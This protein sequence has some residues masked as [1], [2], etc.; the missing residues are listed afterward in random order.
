MLLL[1]KKEVKEDIP[2]TD[3][4]NELIN[5]V[6]A[7]LKPEMEKSIESKFNNIKEI[8]VHEMRDI[9]NIQP[10]PI[11]PLQQP[12]MQ[13]IPN[14]PQGGNMD[15]MGM[16]FPLLQNVLKPNENNMSNL[17]AEA[18][19]RKMLS[20]TSRSEVLNQAMMNHLFK[21]VFKDEALLEDYNKT[22]NSFMSPI[23]K[24]GAKSEEKK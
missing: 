10:Q 5:N 9:R 8:I 24:F 19:M 18:M 2:Q 17:L 16:L 15:I 22:A 3:P 1:V 6:V 4:V 11:Q 14:T 13:G 7:I 21:Q 12:M 23:T 20:D